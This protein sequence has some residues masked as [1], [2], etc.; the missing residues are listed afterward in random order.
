MNYKVIF[1]VDPVRSE[2]IQMAKF[3]KQD[4]FLIMSFEA[5][6]DCFR[7]MQYLNCDLIYFALREG[8]SEIRHL[9]QILDAESE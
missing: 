9:A 2:R 8:K 4:Q 1:V 5:I 7:Q 6:A 3:V